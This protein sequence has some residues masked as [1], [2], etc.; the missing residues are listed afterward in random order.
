LPVRDAWEV[1]EQ[2]DPLV[3]IPMRFK[4]DACEL[5]LAEVDAFLS[6][7]KCPV[8]EWNQQSC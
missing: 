6:L 8:K 7:A 4:T 3:V 1:V 5:P 2:L